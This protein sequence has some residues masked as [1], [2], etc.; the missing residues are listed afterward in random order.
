MLPKGPLL[1]LLL[2]I[3]KLERLDGNL[4]NLDELCAAAGWGQ[5]LAQGAASKQPG[6]F[7]LFPFQQAAAGS[8]DRAAAAAA[9]ADRQKH[10][11]AQLTAADRQKQLDE[12]L[13]VAMQPQEK[14]QEERTAENSCSR[15]GETRRGPGS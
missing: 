2:L 14:L 7:Q 1:G 4:T 5:Y 15:A 11:E 3:S 6:A 13:A 9:A 8:A 10:L 12:Q